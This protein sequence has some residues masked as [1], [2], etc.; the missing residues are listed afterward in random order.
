V[1]D[2]DDVDDEDVVAVEAADVA[3]VAVMLMA[4][5]SRFRA[6]TRSGISSG[7]VVILNSVLY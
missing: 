6:R 3:V 7:D 5:S 4:C 2:E 1:S